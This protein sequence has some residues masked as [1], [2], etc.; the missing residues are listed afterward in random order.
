MAKYILD[1]EK[2]LR[3]L[4]EKIEATK[5]TALD[6]GIDMS[7]EIK[8]QQ[9][10]LAKASEELYKN[11]TRW[12]RVQMARHP[13]RPYTLDYIDKITESWMELHGDRHYADDKAVVA[14]LAIL[15]DEKVIIIG[16]QKGRG[17]RDNVYR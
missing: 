2:P 1:F 3:D 17:T 14:G 10:K 12:Q 9:E 16:Q 6:R 5:V 11:I 7:K 4:E 13:E 15:G 8:S